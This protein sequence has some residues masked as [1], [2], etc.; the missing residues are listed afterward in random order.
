M[1]NGSNPLISVC[2][3][4]YN[5]GRFFADALNSYLSQTYSPLE[6][7]VI[8]DCSTDNS[9]E[10]INNLLK[11]KNVKAN[12][13]VNPVN[14][15]ICKNMNLAISL[16][17]GKYFSVVASDDYFGPQRYERLINAS[18]KSDENYKLFYSN[19]KLVDET[20]R[21]IENDFINY[22]RPGLLVRE[23]NVFSELL[24]GN[25][26]PAIA[27]LIKKEVFGSIGY[28][29]ETLKLEDYDM[30]LRI[31]KGYKFGYV[32][33]NEV[34]YRQLNNSL[35]RTLQKGS[36]YYKEHFNV[37]YKHIKHIGKDHSKVIIGQLCSLYKAN[38][39]RTKRP[40]WDM[41]KKLLN[42]IAKL[43]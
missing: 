16:S 8:D 23:G 22:Y 32:A 35:M 18:K 43:V 19:C 15:G 25:F 38:L 21:V 6:L 39:K 42:A 10:I 2:I 29:D 3:I 9:V 27:L 41:T 24:K 34:Y 33:D 40:D 5:Q 14:W 7:I 17:K 20:G 12:F 28:F 30:W 11:E 1:H 31:A 26:I 37:L 36:L 4:N 13:I